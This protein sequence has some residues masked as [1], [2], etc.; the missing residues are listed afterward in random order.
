MGKSEKLITNLFQM[1][2][3]AT[4]SI[5]FMDEIGSLCNTY[6]KGN[7]KEV[8]Y[9]IKSCWCKCKSFTPVFFILTVKYVIFDCENLDIGVATLLWPNVG[10]K[11]NTWKK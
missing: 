2:C 9:C 4:P 1:T 3:E 5:I 6:G 8:Y 7:E 11:P 10:V